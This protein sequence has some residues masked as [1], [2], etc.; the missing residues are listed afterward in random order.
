MNSTI[1]HIIGWNASVWTTWALLLSSALANEPGTDLYVADVKPLLKTKCVACHGALKQESG[2]RLDTGA[3]IRAGG[4]SGPA[5]VAGK[6]DESLLLERVMADDGERM[7]PE[8]EPLTAEQ[9]AKL[10]R[11]I[12]AGAASPGNEVTP[13]D[14]REHWAF[15]PVEGIDL[16]ASEGNPVDQLVRARLSAAQLSPAPE[17][18]AATVIRRMYLDLHGLPPTVEEFERWQTRWQA[19][20]SRQAVL[21]ARRDLVDELL[22]SPRYGERWAQHWLDVVRYADT[23]GFE[24]NTP[25]ENAWPYRDYVIRAFNEDLPYDQFIQQQLAGDALGEDAATGFLVAA[26][27]LLPGQIGKDD[28]SIRLARQDSL[29]EIIVGTTAT[30]LGLTVGCARCH[31]HK[32]DPIS[33]REYYQLASAVAGVRHGSRS[34]LVPQ[35]EELSA[36]SGKQEPISVYAVVPKKPGVTHVLLRGNPATPGDSVPPGGV[37]AVGGLEASFQLPA[38]SEDAARRRKLAEWI[39]SPQNPLFARV[40]VNRLWHYHFGAGLVKTPNDFG[41]HGGH[42][43]HPELLDWLANELIQSGWSLKH[44]HRLIVSSNTFRQ[45]SRYRPECGAKDAG[46]RLLWRKQAA[47]MEAEVLRD[48]ILHV[49]GQWNSQY[50]GAP[51]R[52]FETFTHNTQFYTTIDPDDRDAYRRTV[53]RTW[54][55][56]GRNYFLDAFDCPDPSTTAPSRAVTTTP[57]QSLTLMNNSFV[58]RM[59]DRFADRLRGE[60]GDDVEQQVQ[61][62]VSLAYGREVREGEGGRL[63]DFVAEH[64]LSALCRVLFNSNEFIYVD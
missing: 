8:G 62:A 41:F 52:D 43:S 13:Q 34:V 31:D 3:F 33:Q 4:D 40:I 20:D 18:P 19:A 47:R 53:Y 56:S 16:P 44:V 58:L 54:V 25:R 32:F 61:R 10:R 15:Q 36:E 42:P 6:A 5:A 28:A 57:I 48:S 17:A 1:R 37:A 21:A 9:V 14:P 7:P 46:N 35:T 29:D 64:G 39:T 60:V 59:A 45:A 24:V 30:A 63:A 23:H 12:E 51:Y 27:V 26:P 55:R 50:G 11:W 22:A 38:D 49:S 2:L